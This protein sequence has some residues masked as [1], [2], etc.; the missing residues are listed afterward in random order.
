MPKSLYNIFSKNSHNL[1]Y[2]IHLLHVIRNGI[3]L[4]LQIS[5]DFKNRYPIHF[6]LN[7]RIIILV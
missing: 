5:F 4:K 1:M 2:R 7:L 6:F 3:A